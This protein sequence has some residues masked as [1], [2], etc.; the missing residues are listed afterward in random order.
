MTADEIL[1]AALQY[2]CRRVLFTG[3]EPTL[4]LD[5]DLLT[6]F[7]GW[8]T[9]LETNG[10]LLPPPGLDWITCSPK[11]QIQLGFVNELRYALRI[12][13]PLPQPTVA[14]DYYVLSPIFDGMALNQDNL[15]WCIDLCKKNP[16]WQLSVQAHK[17]WGI[18]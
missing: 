2:D 3:G 6:S 12:G 8:Y 13:D 7:V 15:N 10:M 1:V 18:Q 14:A 4:Q 9:A 11:T 17:L 5:Y 16:H